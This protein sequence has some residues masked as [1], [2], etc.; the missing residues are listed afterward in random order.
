MQRAGFDTMPTNPHLIGYAVTGGYQ[1]SVRAGFADAD[2]YGRGFCA[3]AMGSLD[4]PDYM[5]QGS[6]RVHNTGRPNPKQSMA[7]RDWDY[8]IPIG[9]PHDGP[10]PATLWLPKD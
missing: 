3:A 1:R 10:E 9:A 4:A 6:V 8:C 2:T 7:Y 5:P